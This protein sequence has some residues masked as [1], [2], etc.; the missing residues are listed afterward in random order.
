MEAAASLGPF[1]RTG[2]WSVRPESLVPVPVV[3]L[4]ERTQSWTRTRCLT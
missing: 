4:Y 3:S 2:L 1:S